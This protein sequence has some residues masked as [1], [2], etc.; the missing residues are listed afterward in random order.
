MGTENKAKTP[1][2]EDDTAPLTEEE[3]KA[4][5]EK[6]KRTEKKVKGIFRAIW[7]AINFFT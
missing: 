1:Q 3:L 2:E 7:E 5:Q 6:D 4:Y